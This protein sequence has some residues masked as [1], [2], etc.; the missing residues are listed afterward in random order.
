[1]GRW[2]QRP[3]APQCGWCPA[4]VGLGVFFKHNFIGNLLSFIGNSSAQAFYFL[5]TPGSGHVGFSGPSFGAG[6]GRA[7]A[8]PSVEEE[9]DVGERAGSLQTEFFPRGCQAFAFEP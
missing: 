3:V 8:F 9:Q 6:G 4:G 2:R 1:M 7:L 5:V